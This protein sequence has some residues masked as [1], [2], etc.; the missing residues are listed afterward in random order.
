MG[1]GGGEDLTRATSP[2]PS[3]STP[4]D[5]S[6]PQVRRQVLKMDNLRGEEWGKIEKRDIRIMCYSPSQM[7]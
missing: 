5:Q 1:G 7:V 6:P 2:A 4:R 3:S